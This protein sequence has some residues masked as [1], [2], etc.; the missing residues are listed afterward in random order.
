MS[1][2]RICIVGGGLAGLSTAYHLLRREESL[3]ITVLESTDRVGGLLKSEVVGNYLFDTGGSHIIF[4]KHLDKLNEMLSFL[5]DNYVKH[6]R[7]TKIYYK[8]TYVKYPFENGLHDLPPEERFECVWGAVEAY[9]K[10]LKNELREPK[11]FLEWLL[12]VFGEG[13]ANKY[14]IPYNEKIWKTNLSEITL[15]WVEGRVPTPPIKE[16]IM[17]AV[18]ISVEGYTHQLNFYYP[19]SGG[20]EALI[21]G[22][23]NEVLSS[24]R[25]EILTNQEVRRVSSLSKNRLLVDTRDSCLECVSVVYTAPLKRSR[26]IFKEVL[27]GLSREL[28][29]LRS[30]PVAVVGLGIKGNVRPYHWVYLPDKKYLPHRVAILSNFSRNNAPK[31]KAS[32]IAEISFKNEDELRSVPEDQLIRKSYEDIIEI[33]LVRNPEFEVSRV[34]RWRDAYIIYDKNRPEIIEKIREELRKL[35]IFINGRFG[36]W[37]YLNID[38]VYMKSEKIAEEVIKHMKHS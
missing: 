6:Y 9:I 31:G 30:V 29:E 7:N 4:S 18:G 1:S 8:G 37:E 16:I 24:R 2:K 28:E 32:I 34:W 17:S 27:G 11:N 12:Y 38:A 23:L 36:A 3:R 14:L 33:D 25:V 13:I 21:R 5:K 20:I 10:R 19:S 35:G 26:E 15:E 22:L